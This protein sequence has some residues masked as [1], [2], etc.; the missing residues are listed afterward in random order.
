MISLNEV[1]IRRI[2]KNDLPKVIDLL[3]E[4][5]VYNPPK[6]KYDSI[7][8]RYSNQQHVFGYCFFYNQQL[9]GY[10]SINLEMKLKKGLMAYLEDV[11]VHRA[12]RN[13]K[14]GG[15][16]V[17][18]L[19]EIAQKKGCY[20]IKLDCNK[21]NLLFYEKLGFQENGFSMAKSL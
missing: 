11:V 20:K 21:N 15:L 10:G 7:W 17:D 4:I 1:L 9:I 14:I 19:V 12:Y 6:K 13:K 2:S 16:I 3:Q 5:S 18:Y 8:E